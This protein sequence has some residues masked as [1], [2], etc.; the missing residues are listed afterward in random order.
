MSL[1]FPPP[2]QH[3]E[4]VTKRVKRPNEEEEKEV[5]VVRPRRRVHAHHCDLIGEEF[6]VEHPDILEDDG[7]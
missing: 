1:P 6:W 4:T 2:L 5:Q 7:C 3:E